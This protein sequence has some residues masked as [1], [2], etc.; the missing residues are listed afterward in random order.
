MHDAIFL[1]GPIKT[2]FCQDELHSNIVSLHGDMEQHIFFITNPNGNW[3]H[4][5]HEKVAIVICFSAPKS[6][7]PSIK[8]NPWNHH[9]IEGWSFVWAI[10]GLCD[11]KMIFLHFSPRAHPYHFHCCRSK[12]AW[13][14]YFFFF[15][16]GF[17][18]KHLRGKL[19]WQGGVQ[20]DA[21]TCPPFIT[22]KK[23]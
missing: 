7:T 10:L 16:N 11:F 22:R 13:K 21:P 14:I 8:G 20:C 17:F 3:R 19:K 23:T 15:F 2:F 1:N 18:K 12:N 9:Q 4:R 5:L 6:A